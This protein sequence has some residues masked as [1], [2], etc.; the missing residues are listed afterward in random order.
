MHDTRQVFGFILLI[1]AA[2]MFLLSGLAIPEAPRFKYLGWGLFFFVV[3][4]IA[5]RI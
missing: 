1:L 5:A 4:A 3:V 2:V